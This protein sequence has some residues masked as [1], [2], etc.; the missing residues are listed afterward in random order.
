MKNKTRMNFW[1][2]L[3]TLAL[4]LSAITF[5]TAKILRP[6]PAD[7]RT[8]GEQNR[9]NVIKPN[10]S[11]YVRRGQLSP[12][13]AMNL[14]ALGNRLEKPGKERLTLM[15]TLRTTTAE[16]R[17]FAATLEFPE[18]LRLVVGGPKN[19]V[20]T[21]DG[22]QAEVLGLPPTADELD[23][24]ETL[25]YDSAEHFFAAQMQGNAMRFLGARFRTDDGS[26]PDYDGPYFDIYK[27]ADQ[28]KASGQERAAKLYYFNSDTLLLERVTYVANR[29]GSE[30]SVETKLTDWRVVDGQQV[31]HRIERLENGQPVFV[32]NIRSAGLG[33]RAEDGIFA[34]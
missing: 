23:L 21:F 30:I 9:S 16:M 15:G 4:S 29:A 33:Q 25:A 32:L 2:A 14:A 12:R 27:I 7:T 22:E 3:L 1:L 24:I 34:R 17:E 31:A 18:K 10:R 11:V 5:A 28:I 19:R 13:L 26:T 6:K 20:V 8:T